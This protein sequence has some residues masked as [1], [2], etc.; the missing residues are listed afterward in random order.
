MKQ[1]AYKVAIRL[2]RSENLFHLRAVG[3]LHLGSSGIGD[4]LGHKVARYL[5]FLR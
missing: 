1:V 3:K 2:C 4:Q 5:F